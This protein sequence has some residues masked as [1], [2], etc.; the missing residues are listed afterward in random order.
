[1]S[2]QHPIIIHDSD[3]EP[4]VVSGDEGSTTTGSESPHDPIPPTP[5]KHM[6]SD[7]IP[8]TP[9]K[10]PGRLMLRP[11][12][13]PVLSDTDSAPSPSL[14]KS[15]RGRRQTVQDMG[16]VFLHP[17]REKD[18]LPLSYTASHSEPSPC[19]TPS[20]LAPHPTPSTCH[21]TTTPC[22]PA[23]HPI[24]SPYP[25]TTTP[26]Q[27]APHSTPSPYP[28][29]TSQTCSSH[30]PRRRRRRSPVGSIK[31]NVALMGPSG[32][33]GTLGKQKKRRRLAPLKRIERDHSSSDSDINMGP[34]SL[35]RPLP[36]PSTPPPQPSSPQWQPIYYSPDSHPPPVLLI[37]PQT[38]PDPTDT[39][40]SPNYKATK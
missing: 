7:I 26:H 22:Q 14:L 36:R 9:Q 32:H 31:P 2:S 35:I 27:P 18:H 17:A 19:P 37:R 1:M 23:S 20:Q 28:S 6:S 11:K 24:P 3:S 10:N 40:Y 8:P 12:R 29:I 15:K 34:I 39:Q 25:S 21:S 38:P 30:H 33:I 16:K 4:V 13:K 5:P